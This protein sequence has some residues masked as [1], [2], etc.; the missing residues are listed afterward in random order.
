MMRDDDEKAVEDIKCAMALD[1]QDPEIYMMLG[2]LLSDYEL[3]EDLDVEGS[4]AA[5]ADEQR[6]DAADGDGAQNG[7]SE[8]KYI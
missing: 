8:E 1:P 6:S 5:E 3:E 7:G 4:S 2:D